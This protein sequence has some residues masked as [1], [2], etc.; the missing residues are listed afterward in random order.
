MSYEK[1]N[2]KN[3][4]GVMKSLVSYALAKLQTKDR[5]GSGNDYYYYQSGYGIGFLYQSNNLL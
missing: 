1:R 3:R 5:G 2:N 4:E